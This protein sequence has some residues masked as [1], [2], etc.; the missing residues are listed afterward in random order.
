MFGARTNAIY[1]EVVSTALDLEID[2]IA[3]AGDRLQDRRLARALGGELGVLRELRRLRD[4]NDRDQH[5]ELGAYHNALLHVVLPAQIEC[6]NEA[7]ADGPP[8]V[9]CDGR[10]VVREVSLDTFLDAFFDDTDFA[11][12]ADVVNGMLPAGKEA[13][14]F[15]EA[16]FGVVNALP[17]HSSELQARTGSKSAVV[18]IVELTS[19]AEATLRRRHE[20]APGAVGVERAELDPLWRRGDPFPCGAAWL[21]DG[22]V[23]SPA[24]VNQNRPSLS[25]AER[26]PDC[27]GPN[28]CPSGSGCPV[29]VSLANS[30]LPRAR[31]PQPPTPRH[32]P[33]PAPENQE[34]PAELTAGRHGSH[35]VRQVAP[36]AGL[37]PAT[38]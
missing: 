35:L 7:H 32:L 2:A 1:R 10:Y 9:F 14:G 27:T 28:C 13:L 37:E 21:A 3:R 33:R 31:P 5:F 20:A 25:V 26:D 38:Q 15:D 11:L 36:R 16:V 22:E 17:P 23:G 8:M 34:R 29:R 19:A 6:M 4:L 24:T 30:A 18:E 12:E